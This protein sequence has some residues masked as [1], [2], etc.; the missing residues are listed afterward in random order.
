MSIRDLFSEDGATTVTG[1]GGGG[2]T[3]TPKIRIT[4]NQ[5]LTFSAAAAQD[6]DLVSEMNAEFIYDSNSQVALLRPVEHGD[7]TFRSRGD[8][9]NAVYISFRGVGSKIGL[10]VD[11]A[12]SVPFEVDGGDIYLDLSPAFEAMESGEYESDV[13]EEEEEEATGEEV[14]EEPP[15]EDEEEIDWDEDED[16]DDDEGPEEGAGLAF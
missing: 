12:V 11:A 10:D 15:V 8:E 7:L 13:Q 14:V 1:G 3:S 6:M 16:E 2:G 9:S 5:L 4:A